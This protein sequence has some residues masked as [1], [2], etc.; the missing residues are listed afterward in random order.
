MADIFRSIRG[1]LPVALALVAFLAALAPVT[2]VTGPDGTPSLQGAA[3]LAD[4]DDDDRDDDDNDDDWDDDDDDDDR[5]DD[6][7]DD[8]D[9]DH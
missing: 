8:D 4:D 7:D 5:D 9:E 1:G 2:V 3:A 6:D